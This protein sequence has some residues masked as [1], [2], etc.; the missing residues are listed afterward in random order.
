MTSLGRH[1]A[2]TGCQESEYEIVDGE[3]VKT[4]RSFFQFPSDRSKFIIWCSLIKRQRSTDKDTVAKSSVICDLHFERSTIQQTPNIKRKV[5]QPDAL[6]KFHH[7]NDWSSSPTSSALS[8]RDISAVPIHCTNFV[9]PERGD[10]TEPIHN[11]SSA[12]SDRDFPTDLDPSCACSSNIAELKQHLEKL[13][14]EKS[15]LV[16]EKR[17]LI[18]SLKLK[19]LQTVTLENTIAELQQENLLLKAKVREINNENK[20]LWTE[21]NIIK[22]TLEDKSS[23]TFLKHV[24]ENDDN[25]RIYSGFPSVEQ[26]NNIYKYLDPGP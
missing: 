5:L 11:T 1:R 13:T 6:P 25:C 3:K 9:L 23:G 10:L 24:I 8:E 2:A 21:A 20:D 7:W 16:K 14:E 18:E 22:K 26:L 12:L 4:D 17:Q 19:N 15:H